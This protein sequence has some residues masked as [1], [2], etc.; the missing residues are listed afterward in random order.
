MKNERLDKVF[1]NEL[2]DWLVQGRCP[3]ASLGTQSPSAVVGGL[4]P[5]F[6]GPPGWWSGPSSFPSRRSELK[7]DNFNEI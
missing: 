4:P 1:V 7:F 2:Q 5:N 3:T 6:N